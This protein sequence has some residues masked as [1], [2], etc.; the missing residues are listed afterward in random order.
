MGSD[1]AFWRD[2]KSDGGVFFGWNL[3]S[4]SCFMVN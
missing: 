4:F 2:L 1:Y 3:L